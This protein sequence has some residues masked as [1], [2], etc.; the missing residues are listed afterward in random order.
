MVEIPLTQGKVALVDDE[1]AHLAQLRWFA[2]KH[3]HTFYAARNKPKVNGKHQGLI[4]L[5]QMVMGAP[6]PGMEIDHINGNGLDNRRS[7]LR[8]VS[9]KQNQHNHR[10]R[11][12]KTGTHFKGV[13]WHSLKRYWWSQI[14]VDGKS[15]CLGLFP[16]PEA[17]ARAYDEAALRYHGEHARLN[18]PRQAA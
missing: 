4:R 6:P 13:Y 10:A 16:T 12:A 1:D 15:I 8:F 17:G 14:Q 5:H 7:N 11:R 9:H 3:S 18:F 2:D